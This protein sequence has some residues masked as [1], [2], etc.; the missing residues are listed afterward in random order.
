MF[1]DGKDRSGE[2]LLRE[3]RVW[4]REQ[5]DNEYLIADSAPEPVRDART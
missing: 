5:L 2:V 4:A 1:D 3:W